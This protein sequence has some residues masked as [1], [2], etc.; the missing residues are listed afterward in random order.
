MPVFSAINGDTRKIFPGAAIAGKSNRLVYDRVVLAGGSI[1]ATAIALDGAI[2]GGVVR[3][4]SVGVLSLTDWTLATGGKYLVPNA[5]YSLSTN[6][7]FIANGVGQVVGIAAS[8]TDLTVTLETGNSLETASDI[9]ELQTFVDQLIADL[10][11]EKTDRIAADSQLQVE[12]TAEIAARIAADT[13]LQNQI[14][15]LQQP[16]Y[17]RYLLLSGM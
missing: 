16:V 14:T 15:Q 9:A 11:T 5:I 1:Q 3:G 6:G 13:A 7:K 12:L 10:A 8:K 17:A 4:D 2:P